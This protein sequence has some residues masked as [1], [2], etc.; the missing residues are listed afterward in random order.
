[1]LGWAGAGPIT[2]AQCR[3]AQGGGRVC[4]PAEH[5]AEHGTIFKPGASQRSGICAS[6]PLSADHF[7]IETEP[8]DLIVRDVCLWVRRAR[9]GC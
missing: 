8:G 4:F 5:G 2:D 9:V 1:M 6:A 3:C 7:A